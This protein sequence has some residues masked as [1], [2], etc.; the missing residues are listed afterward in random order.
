MGE[1]RRLSGGETAYGQIPDELQARDQWL[2]WDASAD[3]G[4]VTF[5]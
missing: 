3:T 5:R 1:E 4:K 2:L